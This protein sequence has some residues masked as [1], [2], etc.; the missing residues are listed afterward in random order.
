ME[1]KPVGASNCLGRQNLAVFDPHPAVEWLLHSHPSLR[2]RIRAAQEW[3][4][5]AGAASPAEATNP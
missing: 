5:D 3:A 2:R 4:A 1:L